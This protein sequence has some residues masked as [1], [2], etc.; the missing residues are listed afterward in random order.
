VK[1]DIGARFGLDDIAEVHRAAE[2]RRVKGT[3]LITP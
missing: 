3:I 2:E 1:A